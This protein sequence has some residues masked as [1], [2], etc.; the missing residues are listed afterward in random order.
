M[1]G[2]LSHI[3]TCLDL[4]EQDVVDAVASRDATRALLVH[5]GRISAPNSGVAKVILVFARLATRACDWIDGD[6]TIELRAG[7]ATTT[8]EVSTDLGG[9][10]RERVFPPLVFKAPLSE[11]ARA[12]ERVPH[13]IAPLSVQPKGTRALV[14]AVTQAVRLTSIPPAPIEISADSLFVHPSPA[15]VPREAKD[16]VDSG[17]ED[18]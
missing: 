12:V 16:D 11:F 6:L 7:G 17:W 1:S 15:A 4:Q 18:E 9:G 14:L 13:M 8:V 10:L 3:K 2:D 5:L